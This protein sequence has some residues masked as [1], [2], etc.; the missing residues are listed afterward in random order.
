MLVSYTATSS[1][2][3]DLDMCTLHS[4]SHSSCM[5]LQVFILEHSL[6]HADLIL[7]AVHDAGSS[8]SD[9]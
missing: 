9:N 1:P 5:L 8:L 3:L 7:Q 6:R 4:C 2:V